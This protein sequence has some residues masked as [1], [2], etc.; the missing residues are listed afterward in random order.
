MG[1][2]PNPL[3]TAAHMI[4][5]EEKP[6]LTTNRPRLGSMRMRHLANLLIYSPVRG[7]GLGGLELVIKKGRGERHTATA[8]S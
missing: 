2:T 5:G 8:M 4:G 1:L 7:F 6:K 3:V